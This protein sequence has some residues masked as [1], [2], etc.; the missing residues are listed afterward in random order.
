[1]DLD[2]IRPVGTVISG[3]INDICVVVMFKHLV[4]DTY[5]ISTHWLRPSTQCRMRYTK[6]RK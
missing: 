5:P 2:N 6:K 1:M 4:D 3:P